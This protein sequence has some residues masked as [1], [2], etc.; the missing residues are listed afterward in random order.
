LAGVTT[1]TGMDNV[2]MR[3]EMNPQERFL[4][5]RVFV[6][7]KEHLKSRFQCSFFL[8]HLVGF[9]AKVHFLRYLYPFILKLSHIRGAVGA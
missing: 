7:K 8:P 9:A 6:K 3:Y 2:N 4:V 1:K 5:R